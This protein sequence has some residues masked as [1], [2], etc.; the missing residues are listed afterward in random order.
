MQNVASVQTAVAQGKA[1]FGNVNTWLLWK[2]TGDSSHL[3]DVSNASRTSL[4]NIGT[5]EWDKVLCEFFGVPQSILPEI[6]SC[7]EIYGSLARGRLAGVPISGMIGDQMAALVGQK[8]LRSGEMKATYGTGGFILMNIGPKIQ[9]SE[10]G[11]LTTVAYKTGPDSLPV[12]ALEGSISNAGGALDWLRD[13]LG[14]NYS[15]DEVDESVDTHN[16]T[17]VCFVPGFSGLF[18]PHWRPDA[19][20]V[21]V[22]LHRYSSK[23]DIFRAT[24]EAVAY[25]TRDVLEAFTEEEDVDSYP[26]FLLVDGWLTDSQLAMQTLADILGIPVHKPSMSETAALGA[27]IMAGRAEGVE[28]WDTRLE[29]P[30]AKI[31]VDRFLPRL[32]REERHAKYEKWKEALRRSLNWK[33]SSKPKMDPETRLLSSVPAAAFFLSSFLMLI[34]AEKWSQPS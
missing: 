10:R 5:L 30:S 15:D 21:I 31:T 27:A 33:T 9:F 6:R 8:C 32:S 12:Y 7:S 25:Q 18:A 3:T 17:D 26:S 13:S 1:L 14:I 24:L 28:V 19:T 34:I 23:E 11:L 22:G 29:S 2:L 20:G 4:M 16:D